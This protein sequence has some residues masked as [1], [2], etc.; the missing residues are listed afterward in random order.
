MQSLHLRMTGRGSL[1]GLS[2]ISNCDTVSIV[3]D[4][5]RSA[6]IHRMAGI[7]L[8]AHPAR[9]GCASTSRQVQQSRACSVREEPLTVRPVDG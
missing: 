3:V 2:Q 8:A 9:Y 7:G 1:T 4:K 6:A 5:D